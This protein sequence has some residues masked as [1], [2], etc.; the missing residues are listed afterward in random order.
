M[1]TILKGLKGVICYID[2]ILVTG[3]TDAEHLENL[4]KVLQRLQK[5]G[6]RMKKAKYRFLQASVEYLGHMIDAEGLHASDSK[7]KAITEAPAP[8]NLQE[9]LS[10]LGLINY[11]GR[12]IPNLSSLLHP[13]NNLLC[14]GTPWKWSTECAKAFDL[15]KE[16]LV[17]S[18][19]LVHYDPS[20]PIQLAGDASAYG[21]GAVISHVMRNGQERLI[22]FASRTLLPSEK[23]SQVE[24]EALSLI[25]GVTKF[26][27]YLYG[28]HLPL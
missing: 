27:T 23:N 8:K 28:R 5:H 13:L 2:D 7:L 1:D 24:R 15:A 9:L 16:K 22:A 4:E 20:L 12:F 6:I 11:Y 21:V 25:F 3:S 26:H 14:H 17:S 19:V 10:F 18:S